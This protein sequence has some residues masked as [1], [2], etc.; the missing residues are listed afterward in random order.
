MKIKVIALATILSLFTAFPVAAQGF[1]FR[2]G[3][4]GTVEI[5]ISTNNRR[6]YGR[7]Y[8]RYRS[9]YPDYYRH[10][11][12]YRRYYRHHHRSRRDYR[13]YHRYRRFRRELYQDYY[14][15]LRYD[16]REYFYDR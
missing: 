2:A 15:I 4:S 7:P 1:I 13:N 14:P 6:Y 9:Y 12:Y 3:P 11:R 10:R 8:Y 5:G 16:R